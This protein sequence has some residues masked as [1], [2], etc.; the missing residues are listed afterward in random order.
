L[1]AAGFEE[2][3]KLKV[4]ECLQSMYQEKSEYT[5]TELYEKIY[6]SL[7]NVIMRFVCQGEGDE[8]KKMDELSK[9]YIDNLLSQNLEKVEKYWILKEGASFAD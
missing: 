1:P 7:I 5:T 8:V 6:G 4:N 3:V 9:T 2:T